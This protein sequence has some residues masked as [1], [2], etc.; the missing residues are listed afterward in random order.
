MRI[1]IF[2]GTFDPVH[3]GHLIVAEQARE[4]A[5]LEQ[6]WFMPAAQ[7]PH[8]LK[9]TLTPFDHRYEMLRLAVAGHDAFLVSDLEKHL[10]APNFTVHT[11]QHL[12]RERPNEQWYLLMGG[13]SLLE[14]PTWYQPQ[15]IAAL[16]G[17]VVAARPGYAVPDDL[18]GHFPIQLVRAPLIEISSTDIRQRVQE[19]R[20]IR[21][22]VPR[23]VEC[24]IA[25]HQL[26]RR[27]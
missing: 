27:I 12:H 17:L 9:R 18:L 16:A 2:G 24:Y 19:G 4:Q 21:Y 22:L 6:V 26:Y 13:D 15:Q 3:L 1:G 14:F 11:L 10:P 8:K 20:S 5:R 25:Q 7:P 23:A